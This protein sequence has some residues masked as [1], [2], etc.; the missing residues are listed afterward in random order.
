MQKY[1]KIVAT[2]SDKRCDVEFIRELAEAGIN[3]VRMN[4]AHLDYDGFRKI[5]D[6]TRAADASLAVMMDTKGPEIRTTRTA[7]DMPITFSVGKMV[8]FVGDPEGVTT[9]DTIC[10]VTYTHLPL[11]PNRE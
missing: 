11:P 1:T 2:V 3:V 10:P 8:K 5:V 9:Q 7:G 4:S 6:N